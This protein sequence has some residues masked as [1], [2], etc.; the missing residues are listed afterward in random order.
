MVTQREIILCDQE[1]DLAGLKTFAKSLGLPTSGS[2]KDLCR[3]ILEHGERPTPPKPS[4]PKEEVTL[5]S[6][7]TKALYSLQEAPS[8]FQWGGGIDFEIIKG[9]PRVQRI[10]AYLGE[11]GTIPGKIVRKYS[12]DVEIRFHTHPGQDTAMPSTQ[13]LISFINSKQQIGFIVGGE[14]ILILEKTPEVV[15]PVTMDLI[16]Y[17]LP[18]YGVYYKPEL[19]TNMLKDIE[20]R[21]KLKPTLV[22]RSSPVTFDL[23]IIRRLR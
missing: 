10:L 20:D 8:G 15:S 14:E 19:Q 7:A 6:S 13:D 5:P 9:K 12:Q 3:R 22:P 1:N 11:E 18:E 4:P 17:A 16:S 2:K 21:L 23:N